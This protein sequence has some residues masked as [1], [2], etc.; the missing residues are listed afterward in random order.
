MVRTASSF[1][2]SPPKFRP[3]ARVLVICEDTKSS[4]NYLQYAAIYYRSNAIIEFSHC[5]RTDPKGIVQNALRRQ[6][7]FEKVYCV[8][9]R[10]AH[11]GWDDAFGLICDS[12]KVRIIPSYPCF[13]Y[14]VLCHFEY[15]RALFLPSG[16]KS[17]ADC[18]VE[19]VR[20]KEGL[21][22]YS[23]GYGGNLFLDLLD[24]L[25]YAR[26]NAIRALGDAADT[27]ELNPSTCLHNLL[28]ELSRLGSPEPIQR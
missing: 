11:I 19:R 25:A 18:V 4:K 26:L 27:Q 16:N 2:R 13:E 23:K 14:W 9:D 20:Q 22:N 3:Q 15:S 17:P 5:G 7:D 24:R 10:D 12:E 6:S 8:L 1:K 28:D 21:N